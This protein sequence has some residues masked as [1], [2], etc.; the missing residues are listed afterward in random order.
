MSESDCHT[1]LTEAI[2]LHLKT[3]GPKQWALV[4]KQFPEVSQATFWR[5]VKWVRDQSAEQCLADNLQ[6]C[7]DAPKA[8]NQ[9]HK[10]GA[11]VLGYAIAASSHHAVAV[12]EQLKR[13]GLVLWVNVRDA[14]EEKT[15]LDVLREHSAHDVHVHDIAQ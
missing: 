10:E 3:V 1:K 2:E 14:R 6:P 9:N 4:R 11:D 15:A 7:S 5:K 13:G 8:I 12:Q